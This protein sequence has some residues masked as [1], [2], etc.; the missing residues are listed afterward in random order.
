ML[1]RPP[2]ELMVTYLKI[3]TTSDSKR[4]IK[5]SAASSANKKSPADL[6]SFKCVYLFLML[7]LSSLALVLL[8]R[9]EDVSFF[10]AISFG[11][12]QAGHSATETNRAARLILLHEPACTRG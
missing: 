5:T 1:L 3:L 11:A 4:G 7:R 8:T 10:E 2:P 9:T 6:Q 12:A